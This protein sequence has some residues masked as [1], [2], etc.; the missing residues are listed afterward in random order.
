M[1]KILWSDRGAEI[2]PASTADYLPLEKLRALQLSRL[3]ATLNRAYEKIP[4]FNQRCN[5]QEVTPDDLQSFA[6]LAKFPF[7][8]KTDLRDEYPFGLFAS[9]M[10]DIVR[11]HASSGTTGKPIVVAYTQSDIK[12]WA[13]VMARSLVCGG[14]HKGDILQNAYGYG[15][16]TGGLGMHYGAEE[17]GA[18]VIPISGG[19]TERQIMLMHDF[20]ATAI[21]C[22]PSYFLH[23]LEVA[24]ALKVDIYNSPLRVGFFGAEPWTDEMRQYIETAAGIKALDIYGLSEIIGPGVAQMCL[25]QEGL[26]IFEDHFYPEIIDPETLEVLPD[27]AEGELVITTLTKEA[28]PMI[29]YRTRDLSKIIDEPCSCGRTLRRIARI[30]RRSD[31]MFI[32]RGVNIFPSQIEAGLLSVEETLPHYRIIL[33]RENGLDQMIIE[34]EIT[35]AAFTDKISDLEKLRHKITTAIERVIN[36]RAEIRLIEANS[37]PRSEG[38]I[39]R[40]FDERGQ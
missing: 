16:F 8:V 37:L 23:L 1:S 3:S 25:A 27:G 11:L 35:P 40:L 36:I 18:T 2:H 38:K 4:H 26:H 5:A 6:D 39:K 14:V 9:E 31:D 29:R 30:S 7:T 12:V 15:L 19:N 34:V 28:M 22:T 10:T 17:L 13:K 21:A 33:R 20:G 24:K 32:I